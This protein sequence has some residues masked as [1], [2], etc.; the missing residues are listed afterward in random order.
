MNDGALGE[1]A[2]LRDRV[3]ALEARLDSAI[4]RTWRR[5]EG[6]T[7]GTGVR[8]H[9]TCTVYASTDRPVS[10]GDGTTLRR[11]AEIVGPASIGPG[12]YVNRDAYI[13]ANVTIGAN[14][15]IGP[16]VRL[17][18]DSHSVGPAKR[19][20]GRNTFDPI[21]IGDGTWIGANVT[22]L[23]GVTVGRGCVI[24]AGAV[25]TADVPANSLAGGVPAKIIRALGGDGPVTAQ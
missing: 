14:C 12:N 17:I 3:E 25:V 5:G 21:V 2:A 13:R 15:N 16:F 19:R 6:V 20:A 7:V 8:I 4:P 22:V 11:G 18:T 23:G 24:A 1:I 9:P 10:I